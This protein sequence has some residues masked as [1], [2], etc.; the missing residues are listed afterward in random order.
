MRCIPVLY[1]RKSSG[2]FSD[3]SPPWAGVGQ[4]F[5]AWSN[6]ANNFHCAS[7]FQRALLVRLVSP[8]K[9]ATAVDGVG[10]R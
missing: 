8:L 7:P 6:R 9:R 2:R 4:A 1:D 3:L 10:V 5:Y